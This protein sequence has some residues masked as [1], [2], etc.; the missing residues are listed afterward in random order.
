MMFWQKLIESAQMQ[1]FGL[2][3]LVGEG[4]YFSR[5]TYR[6]YA[7]VNKYRTGFACMVGAQFG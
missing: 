2:Q 6:Q 1:F 5:A 7:M 4:A 3:M